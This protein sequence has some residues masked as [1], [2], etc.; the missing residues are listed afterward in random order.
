MSQHPGRVVARCAIAVLLAAGLPAVAHRAEVGVLSAQQLPSEPQRQFGTGI[1]GAFEGWFD[2]AASGRLF[3]IGYLNRNMAQEIDVPIGPDNRI[4]PGG[5]DMGQPTHFLPGRQWGVF[6]VP[7]PKE[8]T[9]ADQRFTWTIVVNGQS[10]TIPLKLHP[11]YTVTPFSDVAVK[12]TPPLVRLEENGPALQG[13]VA[14]LETAPTRTASLSSPLSLPV[15]MTDDA[16]Y[17]SGTMAVPRKLP[18]PVQLTWSKYRGPGVVSFDAVSPRVQTI[19]GGGVNVEFRGTATATAR[20]SEPGDYVLHLLVNDFS[21]EGGAGE[22]CCWTN[23]LLK[24]TV[25]R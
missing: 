2:N 18:P 10:T 25:T 12:N 6:V 15:W 11:D 4:E 3:L 23:A 13:P 7:V 1:T 21:G 24:V 9:T 5:P 17:A 16:R 20:F 8:F 14:R 19:A 22:V